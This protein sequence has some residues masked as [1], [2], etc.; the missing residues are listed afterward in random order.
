M[1]LSMNNCDAATL[2]SPPEGIINNTNGE[3]SGNIKFMIP[4]AERTFCL[5]HLHRLSERAAKQG[6]ERK[7]RVFNGAHLPQRPALDKYR[8]ICGQGNMI[9]IGEQLTFT[10]DS[11]SILL[12]MRQGFNILFS[13]YDDLIHDGLLVSALV[14]MASSDAFDDIIY[15]NGRGVEPAGGYAEIPSLLGKRLKLISAI[16]SLPLQEIADNLGQRRTALIIDGLDGEKALHPIQTFKIAQPGEPVA[17][18]GLLKQ[19][20]EDG[21]QKGTF[22]FAFIDN[23]RRCAS[24]CKDLLNL[25]EMRVGFCMNEDEAGMLIGDI[26]K[27]FKGIE[28]PNRAVFVNRMTNEI[29]WFRPYITVQEVDP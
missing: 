10:A 12:T 21:P 17:P 11:L 19:I 23:W 27:K 22:V 9:L 14:S 16:E 2:K 28:K 24:Q 1:I 20:A 4:H 29:L 13:G 5:D 8:D 7:T 18:S 25:F 15:F 6:I 26:T 3:K